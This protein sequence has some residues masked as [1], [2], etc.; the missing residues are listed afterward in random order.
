VPPSALGK[1]TDKGD[2]WGSLCQVPVRRALGHEGAFTECHLIR[3][4][5]ELVKGPTWSIF[6]ECQY[7]GHLAKA[8]SLSS[9]T[10]RA[11]STGFVA[12]TSRRDGDFFLPSTG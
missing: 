9:V 3:S 4:A 5:K 12:V 8:N 10:W 2:R 1:E 7:S 11:L 6:A